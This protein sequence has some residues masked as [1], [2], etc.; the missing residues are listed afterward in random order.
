MAVL[1][2]PPIE[3]AWASSRLADPASWDVR[4]LPALSVNRPEGILMVLSLLALILLLKQ[5][6][7]AVSGSFHIL[8]SDN[9]RKAL[10]NDKGYRICT[11]LV[12][13]VLL[14]LYAWLL[15]DLELSRAG[16]WP[17]LLA[18][19][20]FVLYHPLLLGF[21]SWSHGHGSLTQAGHVLSGA[22]VVLTAVSLPLGTLC[23]LFGPGLQGVAC[24]LFALVAAFCLL[25]YY[26]YG[27]KEI[28]AHNF[29]I[30]FLFLYICSFELLPL[31][32]LIRIFIAQ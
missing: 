23:S 28:V 8:T 12:L 1:T 5:A 21:L 11:Q 9:R 17:T 14:P 26:L 19:A 32:V 2:L 29:S 10:F 25:P 27:R 18:V 22:M 4:P 15:T 24:V 7:Q 30:L 16:Y 3:E 31:A 20:I 13:P 6:L